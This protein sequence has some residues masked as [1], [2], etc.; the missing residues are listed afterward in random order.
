M[1]T[2]NEERL[3]RELGTALR[4]VTAVADAIR[5][6]RVVPSGHLYGSV[7]GVL[8]RESYERVIDLLK[9]AGVVSEDSQHVLRW[10]VR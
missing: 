9:D 7:M 6:L 5:Q 10:V 2:T 3:K 8:S 4:A 1:E